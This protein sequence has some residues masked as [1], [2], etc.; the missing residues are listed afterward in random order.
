MAKTSRYLLCI[1]TYNLSPVTTIITKKQFND[2][3]QQYRKEIKKNHDTEKSQEDE[4]GRYN[5]YYVEDIHED[6]THNG[7]FDTY[8]Y[9]IDDSTSTIS[10]VEYRCKP[11][12]SFK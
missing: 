4:Y 8:K 10:L 11:G 12:Y 3:L 7:T 6:V 2:L 5:E 9:R 1:G